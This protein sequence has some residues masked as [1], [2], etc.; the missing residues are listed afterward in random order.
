[1]YKQWQEQPLIVC[2]AVRPMIDQHITRDRQP[3]ALVQTL[4]S[5]SHSVDQRGHITY[6]SAGRDVFRDEG[7]TIQILDLN[8]D[9]DIAAA[10]VTAQQKFGNTLTLTGS[11]E[12]QRNAVAVAVENGLSCKFADTALDALRGQL[13]AEKYQAE[14]TADAAARAVAV[15]VKTQ[16]KAI[17]TG[18]TPH[19]QS[20]QSREAGPL[21]L[22][23]PVV[24]SEKRNRDFGR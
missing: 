8:S 4:K 21:P 7:R 10:L 3:S 13:Q 19:P 18:L 17:K 9:R 22:P 15:Q 12:F 6:Q 20:E 11:P 23:L 24:V 5:L 14:R 2:E 16:E 1:M